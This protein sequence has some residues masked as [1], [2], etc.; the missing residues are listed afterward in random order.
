[1]RQRAGA[2]AGA[3]IRKTW[4][5][6]RTVVAML[7]AAVVVMFGIIAGILMFES[8]IRAYRNQIRFL[9]PSWMC[10]AE[11]EDTKVV[12]AGDNHRKLLNVLER[13]S[14]KIVRG[15]PEVT[16]T[17][18]FTFKKDGAKWEMEIS[19]T[20]QDCMKL[21]LVGEDEYHVYIPEDNY[22]ETIAE[23]SGPDGKGTPNKAVSTGN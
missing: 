14:R 13:C 6:D 11:H 5:K 20:D 18:R 23:L 8:S 3:E 1:M 17:I 15:T 22:F 21:D 10:V 12:L 2:E 7:V 19:Q 9:D 16:D 4:Y